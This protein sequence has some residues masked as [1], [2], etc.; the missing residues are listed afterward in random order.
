MKADIAKWIRR[1]KWTELDGT[2]HEGAHVRDAYNLSADEL[3]ALGHEALRVAAEWREEIAER[4]PTPPTH[5]VFTFDCHGGDR[6]IATWVEYPW[7]LM[8]VGRGTAVVF[9]VREQTALGSY[10]AW[11]VSAEKNVDGTL[12]WKR[13][14]ETPIAVTQ[15]D[16]VH[17]F[18]CA[19][20]YSPSSGD[21]EYARLRQA[22]VH[23]TP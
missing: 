7:A 3:E 13:R 16:L 11:T 1:N 23:Q 10:Q 5:Q 21:L 22:K 18:R 20:P 4:V 19:L 8:R 15:R 12:R 14:F 17:V 9:L 2:E 6:K